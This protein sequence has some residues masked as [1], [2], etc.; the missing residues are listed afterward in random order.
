MASHMKRRYHH[1]K[2]DD[3]D[4]ETPAF[5][6]LNDKESNKSGEMKHSDDDIQLEDSGHESSDAGLSDED[7]APEDVSFKTGKQTALQQMRDAIKNINAEKIKTK[8]KRRKIDEQFKEQKKRKMEELKNARLPED[9]LEG[10]AEKLPSRKNTTTEKTNSKSDIIERASLQEDEDEGSFA[11]TEDDFDH[12]PDFIPF[13]SSRSD[14]VEVQH[15]K[16]YQKKTTSLALTAAEFK[17]RQLYGSRIHRE[18]SKSKMAKR[19]KKKANR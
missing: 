1:V 14:G 18:S 10:I 16:E 4:F 15:I 5:D 2:F 6:F 19:E 9:F 3:D 8:E 17:Y 7:D 12:N 13:E 11:D